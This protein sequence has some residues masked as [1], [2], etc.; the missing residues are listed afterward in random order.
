[1]LTIQSKIAKHGKNHKIVTPNQEKNQW[2][3]TDLAN[4][5]EW[6]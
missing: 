1:M 2:T 3:E 6:N 5:R 4:D